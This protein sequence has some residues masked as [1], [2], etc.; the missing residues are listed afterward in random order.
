MDDTELKALLAEGAPPAR[1]LRFEL[2]V[3]ARI[4]RRC[5]QQ[6]C[7]CGFAALVRVAGAVSRDLCLDALLRRAGLNNSAR[8][9]AIWAGASRG[10]GECP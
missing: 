10:A 7:D 5:H 4:E 3:M 2:A 6:S 8:D 1:D 9:F